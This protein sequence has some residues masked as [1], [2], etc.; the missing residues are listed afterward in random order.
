MK[1]VKKFVKYV[2]VFT[3]VGAF[4]A[5]LAFIAQPN[6]TYYQ[7]ERATSTSSI[8]E[9]VKKSDVEIARDMLAEATAKLDAEEARINEQIAELEAK[10]EEIRTVRISF[11]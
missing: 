3:F 5:G 8:M 2:V 11:P 9:R 7:A 1:K 10:L 4:I 6:V